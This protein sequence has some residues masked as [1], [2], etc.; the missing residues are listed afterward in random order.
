M[1]KLFAFFGEVGPEGGGTM[2]LPGM[3]RVIDDYRRTLALGT[4]GGMA[5]WH[6]PLRQHPFLAKLLKGGQMPDGGRSLVGQMG[7]VKGVPVEVVELTGKPGDVVVTH[8]HV[9]HSA[10]PNVA[11]RPRQMLG[12]AIARRP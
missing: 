11:S 12:K 1:V 8:L 7:D 4:G 5:N 10:S 2:I 6:R 3:H 9:Y